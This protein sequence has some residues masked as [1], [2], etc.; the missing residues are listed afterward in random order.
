M[1]AVFNVKDNRVV[2]HIR[3]N[4]LQDQ[5]GLHRCLFR[6][7]RVGVKV[8]TCFQASRL[9]TC[10]VGGKL[11]VNPAFG[12]P[13]FDKSKFHPGGSHLSPVYGTVVF[14]YVD[15]LGDGTAGSHCPCIL[16]RQY[17]KYRHS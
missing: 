2:D 17:P 12:A 6:R 4:P 8:N 15:P 10:N 13:H 16:N 11:R 14:G 3:L 5:V 9:G 1:A 7:H